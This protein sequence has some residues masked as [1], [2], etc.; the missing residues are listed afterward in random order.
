MLFTELATKVVVSICSVVLLLVAL[1]LNVLLSKYVDPTGVYVFI[2]KVP[3]TVL[4]FNVS[5]MR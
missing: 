4:G 3:V 1:V 5:S 2:K